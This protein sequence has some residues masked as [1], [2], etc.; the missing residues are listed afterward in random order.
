MDAI[1][2]TEN[3]ATPI[4]AALFTYIGIDLAWGAKNTTAAVALRGDATAAAF[5]AVSEALTDDAEIL[6]FVAAHDDGGAMIIAIDAPTRVPNESGRRP[7]EAILSRCMRRAEA[8]PHPANRR[9]LSGADGIIRGERLV[10]AL[11]SQGIKHTPYLEM[12]PAPVRAA[13]EAFPHPAHIALF[14]LEKTLKY[15]AKPGRTA[16]GRHIVLRQY[17]DLLRSLT[18]ADPPLHLSEETADWMLRDPATLKS[19]ALKR[20]EDALDALTCA[21]IALY[22]HRWGDDR[23][24]VVGDLES[25]YIVVPANETMKRCFTDAAADLTNQK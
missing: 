5:L 7:C 16:E 1:Y 18:A 13:F 14:A 6:A 25:G 20:H 11:E 17:A 3:E 2:K 19:A 8:G 22:R 12:S 9:L 10:A 23:C 15:K 21:Y 4:A 24:P